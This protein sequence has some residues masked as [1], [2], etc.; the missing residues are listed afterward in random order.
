MTSFTT[1]RPDAIFLLQF[2]SN[3]VELRL[4]V[5]GFFCLVIK[6]IIYYMHVWVAKD[7]DYPLVSAHFFLESWMLKSSF[8]VL[9]TFNQYVDYELRRYCEQSICCYHLFLNCSFA[10]A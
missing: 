7:Y 4:V 10:L 3:V 8:I 9:H 1:V 6:I 5:Q 2:I